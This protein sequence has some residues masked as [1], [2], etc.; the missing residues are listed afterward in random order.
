M[1]DARLQVNNMPIAKKGT[2]DGPKKKGK[3]TKKGRKKGKFRPHP[4]LVIVTDSPPPPLN[5]N[6]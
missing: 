1:H 4:T 5:Q 3:G 2:V 6:K